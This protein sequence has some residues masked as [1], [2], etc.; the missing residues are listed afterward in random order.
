VIAPPREA[1]PERKAKDENDLLAETPSPPA[2]ELAQRLRAAAEPEE[3]SEVVGE[4][5][6]LATPEAVEIL[7][8]QFFIE[9]DMHVKADIVSGL[10][11]EQKPETREVRLGILAA[12]LPMGQPEEVRVMAIAIGTEF[13]DIRAVSLLQNLLQDPN[14]DIRTVAEEAL[15]ER[16]A[17]NAP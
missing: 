1:P 15:E 11:E 17:R 16:R 9:Q 12:A 13:D 8:Q 4:L 3:R 7:R 2:R 10:V 14:E 6:S 5:W